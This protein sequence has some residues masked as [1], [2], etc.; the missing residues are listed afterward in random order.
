MQ[1]IAVPMLGGMVTAPL[2][3]LFLLTQF[4]LPTHAADDMAGMNMKPAGTMSAP[5]PVD[6]EP[7]RSMRQMARSPN[8][9]S[10]GVRRTPVPLIG[11]LAKEE[12]FSKRRY[13]I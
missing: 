2:L 4:S 5:K 6:A 13:R 3:S 12:V 11:T 8:G 9:P 7:E 1:R 10:T